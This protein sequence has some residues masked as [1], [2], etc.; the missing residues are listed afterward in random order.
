MKLLKLC[1]DS[2]SEG[3][4]SDEIPILHTPVVR[5]RKRRH[6]EENGSQENTNSS[7]VRSKKK[8]KRVTRALN[9]ESDHETEKD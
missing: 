7:K 1:S 8:S 2:A 4:Y 5:P 6:T 9:S 3:D